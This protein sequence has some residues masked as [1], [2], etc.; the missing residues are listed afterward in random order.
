MLAIMGP[1]GSGKTTLLNILSGKLHGKYEGNVKINNVMVE[2]R[3]M[4]RVAGFVPQEDILTGN[5]TVYETLLFYARLKL[6]KHT[7]EEETDAL[8][9]SIL[10]ELGLNHVR[11]SLIG[12]VGSDAVGSGLKRGLSGG[13]RKRLS[14]GCQLVSNPSII[15]MDE[16]TTGLDAFA[17][18]SVIRT[19]LKLSH[20]GRTVI[21]TIHQPSSEI[22]SLF[23][24]LL[25]IGKGRNIFFGS[26]V[27]SL[28]HFENFGLKC[29]TSENPSDFFLDIIHGSSKS[30]EEKL[31]HLKKYKEMDFTN[32][33]NSEEQAIYLEEKFKES[34][35]NKYEIR[36]SP[37]PIILKRQ[38]GSVSFLTQVS[39][40]MKR[41]I[42]GY[43]REPGALRMTILEK[44]VVALFVGL[45]FLQVERKQ[46][47]L[48]DITGAMFYSCIY[49][50]LSGLL[51]SFFLFPAERK[52]F[53][54]QNQ[55]GL[56]TSAAYYI[57]KMLVEIPALIPNNIIFASIFYWLVGFKASI[58]SFFIYM[59]ITFLLTNVAF[60]VGVMLFS[61]IPDVTKVMQIFPVIF[62][63]L[64]IFSGF[65]L[66]TK[67]TPPYFIWVE[68]ISFMKYGFRAAMRNE[69]QGTKFICLDTELVN[70][71]CPF[72]SG[73]QWLSFWNLDNF[74]I[75]ADIL[76]L[77]EMSIVFHF[78]SYFFLQRAARKS[79]G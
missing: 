22:F 49:S 69:F 78:V 12:Y 48:Q 38:K 59:A 77:I 34:K 62:V 7:S 19:L 67:N 14:I 79:S 73:D 6:D 11:D 31:D 16:P 63:P 75:W 23:D 9:N 10:I 70:N 36:R 24:K 33:D 46:S 55:D 42:K 64:M 44:I 4:K 1:S 17:A 68:H 56:Y 47:G 39:Q 27:H 61:I 20:Q 37:N 66:N 57:S 72:T 29:P 65:Y 25:L 32:Y 58:T 5:Q 26:A 30:Y 51:I 52:V 45:I 40:L 21:F 60:S 3:M 15:F 71:Q 54:Y 35:Y 53:L 8:I 2:K 28:D 41:Q 50:L 43:V 18:Y 74:P 76:I 13:E